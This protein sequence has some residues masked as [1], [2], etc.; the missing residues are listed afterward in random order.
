MR[1]FGILWVFQTQKMETLSA[2]LFEEYQ[3]ERSV[4]ILLLLTVEGFVR[5]T[6]FTEYEL[7]K[8]E[9]ITLEK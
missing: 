8:L 4:I 3:R 5:Q 7:K 6:G 9:N 2:K 1:F